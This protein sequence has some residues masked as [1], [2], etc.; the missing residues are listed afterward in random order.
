MWLLENKGQLNS[1]S[2]LLCSGPLRRGRKFAVK[3]DYFSILLVWK[4]DLSA[5]WCGISLHSIAS[6]LFYHMDIFLWHPL[7]RH[8]NFQ[9][10]S[11]RSITIILYYSFLISIQIVFYFCKQSLK[12]LATRLWTAGHTGTTLRSITSMF[13]IFSCSYL[14]CP[15]GLLGNV[16]GFVHLSSWPFL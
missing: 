10:I 2:F 15:S 16:K 5:L 11:K 8:I 7:K 4:V 3:M 6:F 12:L 13:S 14:P 9:G 1:V